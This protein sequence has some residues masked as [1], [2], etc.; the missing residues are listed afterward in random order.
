MTNPTTPDDLGTVI[1]TNPGKFIPPKSK[2]ATK[3]R[4]NLSA[5]DTVSRAMI[6]GLCHEADKGAALQAEL[7]SV[8]STTPNDLGTTEVNIS[9]LRVVDGDAFRARVNR[10]ARKLGWDADGDLRDD[11]EIVERAP[12]ALEFIKAHVEELSN[13][14]PILGKEQQ[15]EIRRLTD[16]NSGLTRK[17]KSIAVR[18]DV[19]D[20]TSG[21][22]DN[23]YC[24]RCALCGESSDDSD[25][26]NEI[27][28]VTHS[29]SCIMYEGQP[30]PPDY[31]TARDAAE[32]DEEIT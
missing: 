32:N 14:Q 17:L 8:H 4:R 30:F 20:C 26:E 6:M 24:K 29:E 12:M 1:T 5:G 3:A 9:H 31:A 7:S 11:Y 2:A 22:F 25:D 16:E 23:I 10:L 28:P 19:R 15:A 18:I 13:V 21:S 27:G